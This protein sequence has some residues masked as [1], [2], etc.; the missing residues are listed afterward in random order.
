MS[1][2]IEN[3]LYKF[4]EEELDDIEFLEILSM[5]EIIKN[6]PYFIALS[7]N[8][9]RNE[10]YNI[11]QNE[12]RANTYTKLF[13]D[14]LDNNKE[15]LGILN[16][17]SKYVFVSESA[18]KDYS[19]EDIVKDVIYFNSLTKL[20]IPRYTDAKNKYFF[21]ITY[22]NESKKLRYKPATNI[23]IELFTELEAKFPLYYNIFPNDDVNIPVIGTYFRVPFATKDDYLFAKVISHYFQT[24]NINYT[25]SKHYSSINNLIQN[26]KPS[27]ETLI[28]S[29]KNTDNDF[30]LDYE[31][32]NNHL[33]KYGHS[34]DF[35]DKDDYEKLCD[36][37][38]TS[39]STEKE[40]S[41]VHRSSKSKKP[42][43]ANVKMMFF[44]NFNTI[45][46]LSKLSDSSLNIINQLL[47]TLNE[48]K[49]N[50]INDVPILYNNINDIIVNIND[51]NIT[52]EQVIDN[53]KSV[54]K[55]IN[56]NHSIKT[57]NDL[58]ETNKN[59]EQISEDYDEVRGNFAYSRDHLFEQ[60]NSNK[61]FVNFYSEMKEI[62][63]GGNEDNYEGIPS[64]L[65][66]NDYENFEDIENDFI[67]YKDDEKAIEKDNVEKYWLN[68]KYRDENGFIELLKFLL[69]FINNIQQH[70]GIEIDLFLLSEELFNNFRGIPTKYNIFKK[71]LDDNS[72][73]LADN[74]IMD[75]LKLHPKVAINTDLNMGVDI[76]KIIIDTNKIFVETLNKAFVISIAWWCLN[77]QDK[78]LNN[79]F[80]VNEN[81]L[82]PVYI[83]KW[84][85]YGIPVNIK[86]KTGILPYICSIIIDI[87]IEKNDYLIENT[88]LS[89]DVMK[90]IEDKYKDHIFDLRLMNEKKKINKKT[91]QG[92]I[93]QKIMIENIQNKKF[94]KIATDYI[95]SLLYMPGVNY[96]KI[97][98]YLLGCCLQKIDKDFKADNDLYTNARKDLIDIKKKFATRKETNKKRY[99]RFSP[100]LNIQKKDTINTSITFMKISDYKVILDDE[101]DKVQKW[102]NTMYDKN[103]L[104]PNKIID[105]FKDNS[106]KS[107]I[108]IEENIKLLKTTSRNKNSE[109]EKHFIQQKINYKKM[110]LNILKILNSH[111]KYDENVVNILKLSSESIRNILLDLDEL[112]NI[113]NEDNSQ[114]IN[115]I[116]M[117]VCSRALCLPCNPESSLNNILN[118][119]METPNGFIEENAK[120]LHN[121]I[122][123]SL[124]FSTFPTIDEITQ[125]INK[126]REENKQLKLSILNN[127]S[128]E[129]NQLISNLK[130]AGITND[131]MQVDDENRQDNLN[132][133]YINEG[134]EYIEENDF[135]DDED[136]M[137]E[138]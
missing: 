52:L 75:I 113:V 39:I 37:L 60:N 104:L 31:C 67:D 13:F 87:L 117:Y 119:I 44:E 77:I 129:E 18:K 29:L 45:L 15:K 32:L 11:F 50:D 54:K 51:G 38:H 96:K 58:L 4:E 112:N 5:D 127:K 93:A 9:I 110:L 100:S 106:R 56:T 105:I 1:I 85:A 116:N 34:M 66:N 68:L 53:I 98:K 55:R 135:I 122:L 2:E 91:E 71:L 138:Y 118:C 26:T 133:D 28:E 84:F 90:I 62:L 88:A 137:D 103:P 123:N 73:L 16:D 7:E 128:V 17:L 80:L 125:F 19:N 94:N 131:L 134:N 120:K 59:Y 107:L 10:L 111:K 89:R 97:H 95:N 21:S 74:L 47:E 130:K 65:K 114:D 102:L 33:K 8:E 72:I 42:N 30:D 12:K 25:D 22:D 14:I 3:N 40:R 43:L 115:R 69:P 6:N 132:D 46:K 82:N 83:E 136:G 63:L 27:I 86:E 20:N 48:Y 49:L 36:Y 121:D 76:Q 61:K 24:N 108:L 41:N 99:Q 79:S 109:F 101:T 81:Y 35:L 23:N 57:L 126:K 64:I 70:S 92:I 78:I 124:E